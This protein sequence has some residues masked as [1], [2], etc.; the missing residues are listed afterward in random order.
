MFSGE[1]NALAGFWKERQGPAFLR[2]MLGRLANALGLDEAASS[3]T[4]RAQEAAVEA[5]S[6]ALLMLLAPRAIAAALR[7]GA[8]ADAIEAAITRGRASVFLKDKRYQGAG[9]IEDSVNFDPFERPPG[10][11]AAEEAER[12]CLWVLSQ[13]IVCQ[14]GTL[15]IKADDQSRDALNAFSDALDRMGAQADFAFVWHAMAAGVRLSAAP[16]MLHQQYKD[17]LAESTEPCSDCS[18]FVAH[19]LLAL[20][21]DVFFEQ[22]VVSQIHVLQKLSEVHKAL[23]ISLD[24]YAF[25]ISKFWSDAASRAPF[26]FIA[27]NE[28]ART[29]AAAPA[30]PLLLR[31]KVILRAGFAALSVT[32]SKEARTWLEANE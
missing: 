3:W 31:A 1:N 21:S 10:R 15:V 11:A 9:A 29:I 13:V 32:I 20:R 14:V 17:A 19:A 2:W 30:T 24:G 7:S 27:P 4:D 6:P 28:L 8:W 22:A 26:R 16:T 18:R 5:K 25:A 12:D 23:R